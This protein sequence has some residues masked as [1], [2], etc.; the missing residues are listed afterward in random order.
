MLV[1]THDGRH[2]VE[3]DTSHH[4]FGWVFCRG[5][6]PG[7]WISERPATPS[8]LAAAVRKYKGPSVSPPSSKGQS[9][10]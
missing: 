3:I 10:G 6:D 7:Q 8:E 4:M 2:A 9:D 5:Y 1:E